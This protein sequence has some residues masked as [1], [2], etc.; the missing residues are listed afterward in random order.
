MPYLIGTNP[1]QVPVNGMLGTAAFMDASAFLAGD[2]P[3]LPEAP[4]DGKTYGRKDA[5]WAEVVG[6]LTRSARTGNTMLTAA[7]KGK[8]IDITSG[9]FSQTFDAVATLG[10]GWWCY[11]RNSGTG[12]LTL[13][14]SGAEAIDGVAT[15]ALD[16]LQTVVVQCDGAALR[17]VA[18]SGV[19]N[20][21]VTVNTGNGHGS[22]NTAIRRF[23]TTQSSAGTAITYADSATLGASFTINEPGIYEIYYVDSYTA[24]TA[25][26]FGI[27]LN[28]SQ[29]SS[30][31]LFLDSSERVG[32]TSKPDAAD[33][34][35]T[36]TRVLRLA[37]GDVIRPHTDKTPNV[38]VVG[39]TVFS[40]RKVGL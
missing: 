18:V 37:A 25:V 8:L 28:S 11:L 24:A 6:S 32:L 10:D 20:H 40:I 17:T 35:A 31:I 15:K 23:T 12:V 33:A 29:L 21:H 27:S 22:T 30:G 26:Q 1:E 39:R 14:P 34:P 19:G 2:T 3:V 36:L 9:T 38:V 5:G 16:P 7:D 4:S 13:D